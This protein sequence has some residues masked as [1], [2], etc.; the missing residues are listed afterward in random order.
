LLL[1]VEPPHAAPQAVRFRAG[2][3]RTVPVAAHALSMG[4]RLRTSDVIVREDVIWG[5]GA[6]DVMTA[7]DGWEMRRDVAAGV[8]LIGSVVAAPRVIATGDPVVF[9]WSDHGVRIEREALALAPARLGEMVQGMAGSVR[10]S[11]RATG[12]GAA[13]LKEKGP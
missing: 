1:V 4:Q 10:L 13:Q 6:A 3:R 9:Y 5:S 12:P 11:G 7:L 8:P 2:V